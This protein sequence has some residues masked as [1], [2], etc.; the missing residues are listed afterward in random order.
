MNNLKIKVLILGVVTTIAISSTPIL[1]KTTINC[2]STSI[3]Q[4]AKSIK[5]NSIIPA[6]YCNGNGVRVRS[7]PT[8]NST[9]LGLLYK[10][11]TVFID[12]N[13]CPEING[14]QRI[15]FNGKAGYVASQYL[16]SE[17]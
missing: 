7:Q 5:P 17:E 8:T 13:N 16:S 11:D 1:A 14:F 4:K 9:V 12:D 6:Y 2:R 15:V 10:G 3:V